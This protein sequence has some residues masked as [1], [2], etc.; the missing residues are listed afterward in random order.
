MRACRPQTAGNLLGA[1][2][3]ASYGSYGTRFYAYVPEQQAVGSQASSPRS[4]TGVHPAEA[5]LVQAYAPATAQASILPYAAYGAQYSWPSCNCG[6]HLCAV[7]LQCMHCPALKVCP[8]SEPVV[9]QGPVLP[10]VLT[11]CMLHCHKPTMFPLDHTSLLLP[12]Q[13]LRPL[14]PN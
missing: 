1:V 2:S 4:S 7:R 3:P 14:S 10:E 8:C 13:H 9:V 6:D 11:V 12:H 5:P